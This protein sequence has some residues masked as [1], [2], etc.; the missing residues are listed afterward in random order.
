M[1]ACSGFPFRRVCGAILRH[2][3][4]LEET[5]M[6][7]KKPE[8]LS[9]SEYVFVLYGLSRDKLL[10]QV[11]DALRF[12]AYRLEAG[13]NPSRSQRE[14]LVIE[15]AAVVESHAWQL[16]E[17]R[18]WF[19]ISAA[20]FADPRLAQILMRESRNEKEKH[21]KVWGFWLRQLQRMRRM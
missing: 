16:Y 2:R 9:R 8:T 20:Q 17:T 13:I 15:L 10:G 11:A 19:Y 14:R 4:R 18:L 3:L 12:L 21:L 6:R 1:P 7:P 5:A